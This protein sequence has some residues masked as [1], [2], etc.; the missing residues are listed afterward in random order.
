[1]FLK[2]VQLFVV[3]LNKRILF[4]EGTLAISAGSEAWRG[5]VTKKILK[6][7]KNLTDLVIILRICTMQRTL[8]KKHTNDDF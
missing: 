1:M 7:G 5:H 4:R 3:Y 6:G 2:Y 8:G